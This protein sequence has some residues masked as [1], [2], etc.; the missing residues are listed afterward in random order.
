MLAHTDMGSETRTVPPGSLDVPIAH[1]VLCGG[2]AAW[3]MNRVQAYIE[4]NLETP[5]RI[6]DMAATT[7]LSVGHFSRAFRISFAR[8]PHAYVMLRRTERAK[9]LMLSDDPI[10]L[11]EIA[12]RCGLSDQAHLS[13]LFRNIVGDSPATWRRRYWSPRI[14]LGIRPCP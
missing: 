14:P 6:S 13:R 1:R 7:R 9:R 5:I 2:L 3:Q 8:P 12:L 11:A 10:P 4:E